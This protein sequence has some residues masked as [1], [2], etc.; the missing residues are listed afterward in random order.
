MLPD[1]SN[2]FREL[3]KNNSI[4]SSRHEVFSTQNF[5]IVL[6]QFNC[7]APVLAHLFCKVSGMSTSDADMLSTSF[8]ASS[9]TASSVSSILRDAN[10]Q[11][12]CRPV[13][14]ISS[15]RYPEQYSPNVDGYCP[16]CS[17]YMKY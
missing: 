1:E 11:V 16:S 12:V 8:N 7:A 15:L 14:N 2:F 5:L 13:G 6:I 3:I 4:G 9:L 10:H 17:Q